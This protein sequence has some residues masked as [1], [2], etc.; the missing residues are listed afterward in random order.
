MIIRCLYIV[1]I[2]KTRISLKTAFKKMKNESSIRCG[3]MMYL[4]CAP[5][6]SKQKMVSLGKWLP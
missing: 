2:F 6:I 5:G 3:V 1:S 4:V